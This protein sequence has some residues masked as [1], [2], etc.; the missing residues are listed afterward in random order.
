MQQKPFLAIYSQ[1]EGH[2]V[3]K[4]VSNALWYLDGR[5]QTISETAKRRKNVTATS[6]R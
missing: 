2:N 1:H 6:K 5:V 3:F 4:L